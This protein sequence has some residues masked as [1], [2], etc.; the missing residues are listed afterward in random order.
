MDI[1]RLEAKQVLDQVFTEED[2]GKRKTKHNSY[3]LFGI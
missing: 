2:Y 3:K 1:Y